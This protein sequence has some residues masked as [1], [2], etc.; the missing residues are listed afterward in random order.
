M[1]SSFDMI[2]YDMFALEPN[3][4]V[5]NIQPYRDGT[6]AD[7]LINT[8]HMWSETF[9][10][11][12][13]DYDELA[14]LLQQITET[15]G[16]TNSRFASNPSKQI[17]PYAM[18]QFKLAEFLQFLQSGRNTFKTTIAAV[19]QQFEDSKQ[20]QSEQEFEVK[21]QQ[22]VRMLQWIKSDYKHERGEFDRVSKHFGINPKKME[23]VYSS[24]KPKKLT[25]DVWK[26]LD[27]TDSWNIHSLK[28]VE[29]FATMY[30]RDYDKILM[31]ILEPPHTIYCP[32]VLLR[33]GDY[34]LVAGN[35]RLM[36]C[37]ALQIQPQVVIVEIGDDDDRTDA[38]K[39]IQRPLG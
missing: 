23:K 20:Q 29:Y 15:V 21:V 37:R 4:F 38:R 9:T 25:M 3:E 24:S 14:D 8:R 26:D 6:V 28:D 39:R 1:F 13:S 33:G 2:V 10:L 7:Q 16:V 32:I 18:R 27:N 34:H 12:A 35:T 31:E 36:F 5:R 11:M 22:A 30:G 19:Q 17:E